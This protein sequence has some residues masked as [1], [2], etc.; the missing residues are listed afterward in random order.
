QFI[1][2]NFFKAYNYYSQKLLKMNCKRKCVYNQVSLYC[3]SL[4]P[5]V[6]LSPNTA[7]GRF[8]NMPSED[9]KSSF[10]SSERSFNLSLRPNSRYF[11]P[12]VLNSLLISIPVVLMISLNSFLVGV[13]CTIS[14]GSK[15]TPYACKN[16]AAFL[17]VVQLGYW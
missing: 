7:S 5:T 4:K 9:N 11:A 8:T 13:C 17:Q 6:T 12:C 3:S 16:F 15:L 1:A 2:Q 14:I 10:S